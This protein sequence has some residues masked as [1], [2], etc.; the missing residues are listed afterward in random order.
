MGLDFRG[1]IDGLR[2][3]VRYFVD[4]TVLG[5][6]LGH[7]RAKTLGALFSATREAK[8]GRDSPVRVFARFTG[9]KPAHIP[10][11]QLAKKIGFGIGE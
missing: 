6:R 8:V 3:F 7:S 11:L 5:S 2:E 4:A 1:G 9:G 10:D